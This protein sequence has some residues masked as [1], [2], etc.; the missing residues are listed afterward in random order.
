MRSAVPGPAARALLLCLLLLP[1][2]GCVKKALGETSPERRE[3]V[4]ADLAAFV[5]RD[6][7]RPEGTEPRRDRSGFQDAERFWPSS[8]CRG[9]QESFDRAGFQVAH[10]KVFERPGHS[11]DPID[12]RPGWEVA[13]S[14]A[15]LFL[16]EDGASEALDTWVGYYR[17]P[18]LDPVKVESLG[19]EA[20]GLVGS[21]A[22]PAERV[23]LFVWRRGRLLL[24]LRASTGYDTVSLPAVRRLV[25]RMDDRAS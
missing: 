8:C 14:S 2:A 11:A 21:P 24:S 22:S 6:D 12:T 9:I 20:I 17:A 15:V 3:Y 7:E 25:D 10:V 13:V 18:G 19:D 23:Y 4:A 1:A 16:D 5:L